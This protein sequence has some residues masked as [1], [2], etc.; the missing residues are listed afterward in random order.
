MRTLLSLFVA[1]FVLIG[2]ATGPA[3]AAPKSELWERWAAHD[4]ASTA[5]IDH[6][7]WDQ[8][9]RRFVQVDEDGIGKVAYGHV[10]PRSATVLR[11]YLDDLQ[12][13]P[14]SK[15]NRDQQFAYWVNMYNALTV[16]LIIEHHPVD[17]IRDIDISP[18]L[19]ANGP[20]GKKLM[21]VEGE[22]LSLDDIEH[23]ILRPIWQD[24][25]IHYAVN[26][27]AMGCP[28]LW[29]EAMTAENTEEYLDHGAIAFVNHP[30][31]ASVS[32]GDLT[33]SSI[34]HWF[35][36]DFGDSD[37][38]VID[39]LK[40]YAKEDLAQALDGISRIN[41][42]EYDWSLNALGAPVSTAFRPKR[43]S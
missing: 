33:V 21:T 41:D 2:S 43:G 20:W 14:I 10:D 25:R 34:Y 1:V 19:F 4:P 6:G 5:T 23:R 36:E 27:A 13:V 7:I 32:D 11:R 29:P 28:N 12:R 35:K 40:Q 9:L 39:H 15:L 30:R 37:Q 42:H 16:A 24:P 17:S 31:G 8:W 3:D 26:C 38:G 18:G 22:E